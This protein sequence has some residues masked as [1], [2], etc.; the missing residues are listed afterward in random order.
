M[1]RVLPQAVHLGETA[2]NLF[3]PKRCVGCGKEGF[4]ICA[5]CYRSI[6]PIIPPVCPLCGKP[7][8]SGLLCPGCLGW[9]SEIDGIRSPF[10][11]EGVIRQAVYQLKYRNLRALAPMLAVLLGNYINKYP[12][13][14][15]ILVPVP[16]H[17][18]R[19]RER[20][21][22]Q[23]YLMAKE[24]GKFCGLPVDDKCLIRAKYSLP[25]ARTTNVDERR[26]NVS[27]AFICRDGRL[28]G[29]KVILIDDVSTSGA[30]LNACAA[31]LK[32]VGAESV[33][34]LTL[35]REI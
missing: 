20:G 24:L 34:G 6:S 14:G 23:S 25:Q 5:T 26:N 2:L 12:V 30:T 16:L 21:Y 13:P 8:A 33:W 35:A 3:F 17:K 29:R 7:Q 9:Q 22:N 11:F 4:F 32:G 27:G 28:T 1:G 10:R 19:V 31:A 18:I 15:E